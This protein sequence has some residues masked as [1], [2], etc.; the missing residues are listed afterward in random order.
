MNRNRGFTLIELLVVLVI[1]ALFSGMV[2]V[3]I[4]DSLERKLLSEA[5]RLQAVIIAASDEAVYSGNE[6][7][8]YL[9]KEGYV[10]S[11]WER[12][13]RQWV[14]NP[15]QAFAAY[16]FPEG[17]T[18]EWSIDGFVP[19]YDGEAIEFS[20]LDDDSEKDASTTSTFDTQEDSGDTLAATGE[21]L[22]VQPQLLL[23]STAELSVF[24]V[25][26]IPD[27]VEEIAHRVRV[28]SDGFSLPAINI[29][30]ANEPEADP[31][32]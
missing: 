13:T 31:G 23:L 11:R 17:I 24:E 3:S 22:G 1:I 4:G 14:A 9:S 32:F 21:E 12:L 25:D 27:A 19:P 10:V 5:E 30:N 26:F 28:S 7:G 2:V 8:V 18:I 6:Y 16:K 29:L 15:A 20:F